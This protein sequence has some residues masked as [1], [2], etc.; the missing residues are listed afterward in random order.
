M[1]C[2]RKCWT[3][4]NCGNKWCSCHPRPTPVEDLVQTASERAQAL[5]ADLEYV[6]EL[7]SA[8]VGVEGRR[9]R[10]GRRLM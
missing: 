10:Y 9:I 4:Y 3:P 5:A 8:P 2:C 1:N 6:E 7:M